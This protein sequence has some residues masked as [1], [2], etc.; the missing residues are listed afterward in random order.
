MQTRFWNV[1][2]LLMASLGSG[3]AAEGYF[4]APEAYKPD[5]RTRLLLHFD[6]DHADSSPD[7]RAPKA[8][9][10]RFETGVQG[11]AWRG[12]GKQA[13][14]CA[15]EKP[16]DAS[17]GF[18]A[19]AW[20]RLDYSGD[21]AEQTVLEVKGVLRCLLLSGG[22][23]A[24]FGFDLTTDQGSY[25][26]RSQT[27][28]PYGRWVHAAWSY[29]PSAV[30]EKVWSIHVNGVLLEDEWKYRKRD[31]PQG[32]LKPCA[33]TIEIGRG[34]LGSLDELRVSS[35]VRGAADRHDGWLSGRALDFQ[36]FV[37]DAV[38]KPEPARAPNA[39]V[40]V[41]AEAVATFQSLGLYVRYAG[42]G[43]GDAVCRVAYRA[44]GTET[45]QHGLDLV[46]DRKNQEFRGSLL[47]LSAGSGY[48]IQ[49]TL[50]DPDDQAPTP[51]LTFEKA[52]WSEATPVGETREL[53]AGMQKSS[54]VIEAHGKPDAWIVYRPAPQQKEALDG[55]TAAPDAVLIR[56]SSYVIVEDAT[57]AGGTVNAVRVF[58]SKHIRIRRCEMRG[59]GTVGEPGPE[60]DPRRVDGAGRKINYHAGVK[61]DMGSEAVTVEHCYLH[62]PRGHANSWAQGHPMG[63]EAFVIANSLGRHVIRYN[64]CIGSEGH[65]FNDA[66]E[67]I[68]NSFVNGG[69]YRDTDIHDNYL[70]FCN[71]DV[72]ELDGG[73]IN[74][75]FWNNRLALALCGI[76]CAPCRIG[77]AYIFR[78]VIGPLGDER[79]ATGSAYKMGG[80]LRYSTGRDVILHNTIYGSGRGLSSVGYGSGEDRGRYR[81]FARNNLFAGS[82]SET[83]IYDKLKDAENDFDYDL[84][85]RGGA[86]AAPEAEAHAVREKPK[87]ADE[88][89]GDLSLAEGSPG[90]DAGQVLAGV[91][92]GFSGQAPDMGAYEFGGSVREIPQRPH[93]LRATP[94]LVRFDSR[95]QKSGTVSLTIPSAAGATWSARTDSAWLSAEPASAATADAAQTVALRVAGLPVGDHRTALTFRTD[96]GFQTTV[97]VFARVYPE[98]P[99]E[100]QVEAESG[101]MTGGM[102]KVEDAAAAGGAYVHTP[103]PAEGANAAK[104][105]LVFA[106]DVPEDGV[107]H[108]RARCL[109]PEPS[110]LHD[111]FHFR[112]DD[113]PRQVWGV[114]AGATRWSWHAV[115]V[116]EAD[117]AFT[118][119]LKKGS[120]TLTVE[121]RETGT[122]LDKW[123][124]A[125]HPF[126]TEAE[127]R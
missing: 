36:P 41:A 69:P 122:C 31:T 38:A 101:T 112:V 109:A 120:H 21:D 59:W 108:I 92:D 30:G 127:S 113:G 98:K 15:L 20:V 44:K 79:G 27:F 60:A 89:G 83:D 75:R 51:A 46:P 17:L 123:T 100:L 45:W 124:I 16:W 52:T 76:S 43:N 63:P 35:A 91:N 64:E 71:D 78:N 84:L 19:E 97:L 115:R 85:G 25:Q 28:L 121:T 34:L 8:E 56:N 57:I 18:T 13:L 14:T 53:P 61:I 96:R 104:G 117:E 33:G 95:Q 54:F 49:L 24:G 9:G 10:G 6:G 82:G 93:G 62:A 2:A 119:E 103:I 22:S 125:N 11:Q 58:N 3:C 110:G 12:D 40:L 55:G 116:A 86:D 106:F 72:V 66:I 99:F 26:L 88:S 29:D 67:S 47:N 81:A 65:R 23:S 7:A 107:Y 48:E 74:V 105:K 77:P 102:A 94:A 114:R 37:P 73:Q 42:D 90:I 5:D 80:G 111:S 87:F 68:E 126:A 70:A 1:F 118:A 39:S 4:L 50:S 32:K